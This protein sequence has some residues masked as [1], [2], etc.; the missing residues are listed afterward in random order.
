MIFV[1]VSQCQTFTFVLPNR[2]FCGSR[3]PFP[4][5]TLS[6]SCNIFPCFPQSAVLSCC[7]HPLVA[8]LKTVSRAYNNIM[9]ASTMRRFNCK[10]L[11]KQAWIFNFSLQKFW[12]FT[13]KPYLCIRFRIA[14]VSQANVRDA[15]RNGKRTETRVLWKDLHKTEVVQ[16]AR[17]MNN[18]SW[19]EEKRTVKFVWL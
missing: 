2:C 3:P 10:Q 7:V 6:F 4:Y 12:W 1:D 9:C 18:R 15:E 17:T 13:K 11:L 14:T 5:L 16:E 8:V 19:V